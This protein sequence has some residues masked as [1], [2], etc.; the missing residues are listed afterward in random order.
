MNT[1]FMMILSA[2]LIVFDIVAPADVAEIQNSAAADPF[3]QLVSGIL[4]GADTAGSGKDVPTVIPTVIP[5]AIPTEIPVQPAETASA[6]KEL[7]QVPTVSVSEILQSN[8][9]ILFGEPRDVEN[10]ERGSSGFGINA[11]LN[12]DDGIR[13]IALNN[14]ISL[15][16]KKNNGWLSWRLRPPAVTDGAAEMEFSILTCARG[17]RMG[18]VMHAPNYTDGHGYYFSLAC[19][20]TVSIMRDMTVLGTA[21]AAGIFK[22]SS[23]DTNTLTAII[24]GG[25]L[26][27]VLNGQRVLTVLDNAYPEGYSGFFTAPQNQDTL[28][29]DI[30]TFSSYSGQ[31]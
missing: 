18:L 30:L 4:T 2:V 23:G 19:E 11:G 7:P 10:F 15:E 22:N 16:P 28:T 14:R 25:T 31:Q 20:G 13:I 27:A 9:T 5:T 1:L 26:M 29:M 8:P 17:D 24:S 21:D 3:V 6:Y 12:D